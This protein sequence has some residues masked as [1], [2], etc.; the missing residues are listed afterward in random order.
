LSRI[1][2]CVV[3][4]PKLK[5]VSNIICNNN[6]FFRNFLAQNYTK[7]K[8]KSVLDLMLFDICNRRC[9][10]SFMICLVFG[11]IYFAL[12]KKIQ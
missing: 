1:L 9:F 11:C 7:L 12:G 8:D 5:T 3:V 4:L 10:C 6:H 2:R